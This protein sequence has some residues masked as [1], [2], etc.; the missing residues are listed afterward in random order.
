MSS[1][2][3][4]CGRPAKAAATASEGSA[5][6]PAPC[7]LASSSA[8]RCFCT[9]WTACNQAWALFEEKK[10]QEKGYKHLSVLLVIKCS[11]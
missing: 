9:S 8:C 5:C 2:R 6:K 3:R 4:R 11:P 10:T 7:A 1:Q